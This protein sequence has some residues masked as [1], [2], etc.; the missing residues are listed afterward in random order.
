MDVSTSITGP[1]L[2]FAV[3][4]EGVT[5]DPVTGTLTIPPGRLPGG[6]SM[7]VTATD[8]AGVETGRFVLTLAAEEAEAPASVPECLVPPTIA[9][10]GRIGSPVVLDPGSWSGTPVPD[11]AC[12]WLVDGEAVTG[13]VATTYVPVAADDGRSLSCRVTA[14]N[15]AGRAEAETAAIRITH[16]PPVVAGSLPDLV[17]EA[18]SGPHGIEA[19]P[20]FTGEALAFAVAGAEAT[21]DKATGRVT[22]PTASPRGTAVI[23]VSATNSG[24]T[25]ETSFR[26]TV[27]AAGALPG[28]PGGAPLALGTP[29]EAVFEQGDAV[30][31]VSAQAGFAG[32]D[33][34]YT[35]ETAPEGATID[36]ISGLVRVPTATALDRAGVIVRATNAAGSAT[37]VFPVSVRAN[38]TI[39]DAE[40][41]LADLGF[42]NVTAAPVGWTAGKEGFARLVTDTAERNH[43]DWVHARGDGIYRC[44]A[45]WDHA[46]TAVDWLR[47]FSFTGRLNREGRDLSGIRVEFYQRAGNR[48]S[49]EME[50]RQYDGSGTGSTTLAILETAGW[51]WRTWYWIDVEFDGASVRARF[52]PEGAPVPAW[53]LAAEVTHREPGA[54]GPGAFPRHGKSMTLD[55]R[56][57]E[58]HPLARMRPEPL[59]APVDAEWRIDQIEVQA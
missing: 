35:L 14:G 22:I 45:R 31:T 46:N 18:G 33:L 54:F 24:G 1:A 30:A 41:R 27:R 37:Q 29:G 15:T 17:L 19:A 12:Q 59:P 40:A 8:D 21:I 16:V 32:E 25:A 3:T 6:M 5:I 55:I 58:Y 34:V 51:Q 53:Q 39:F 2:T 43:G 48:P 56:R 49:Q 42:L 36:R 10:T 50:I 9:G 20:V 52:Y 38:R 13:A 28:M 4:G 11:L 47:P 26:V 23:T 57:I 7:A 44:L